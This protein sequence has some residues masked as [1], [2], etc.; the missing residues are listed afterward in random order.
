MREIDFIDD[1][2]LRG[3]VENVLGD[4]SALGG[5][6]KDQNKSDIK[7]CLRKTM[8]IYIASIIEATRNA[9]S[10]LRYS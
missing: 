9:T 6:L 5:L 4:V 10:V 3:R 2:S 1:D 7:S 8:I